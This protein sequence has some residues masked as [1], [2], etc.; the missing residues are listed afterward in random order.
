MASTVPAIIQTNAQPRPTI[1]LATED[2]RHTRSLVDSL[3]PTRREG[4]KKEMIASIL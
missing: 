4:K 2:F 3:N 1:A